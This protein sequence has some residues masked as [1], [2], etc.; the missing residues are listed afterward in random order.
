MLEVVALPECSTDEQL[1]RTLLANLID[2]ALKYSRRDASI[3]LR[4]RPETRKGRNGILFVVSNPPGAAGFPDPA[5]V[6]RKYYRAPAAHGKTGS[7]LGLY[8]CEGFARMLGGELRYCPT[9]D[10]VAF[11]LWLPC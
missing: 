10:T 1:L 8:I 5:Q 7:G 4:A 9:D 3:T 6:F 2:N 11:S